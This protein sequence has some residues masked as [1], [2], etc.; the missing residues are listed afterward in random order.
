MS[1]KAHSKIGQQ[2]IVGGGV[3]SAVVSRWLM[4]FC[5]GESLFE[6]SDGDLVFLHRCLQ[7]LQLAHEKLGD[8]LLQEEQ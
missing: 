7:L 2:L 6:T 3:T 5:G 1:R 4:M 8:V